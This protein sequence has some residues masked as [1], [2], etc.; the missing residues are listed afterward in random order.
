MYFKNNHFIIIC[1]S[2]IN[3]KDKY[4]NFIYNFRRVHFCYFLL[5]SA[6]TL[7]FLSARCTYS[8]SYL[9]YSAGSQSYDRIYSKSGLNLESLASNGLLSDSLVSGSNHRVGGSSMRQ[10]TSL[11]IIKCESQDPEPLKMVF[12]MALSDFFDLAAAFC[13]NLISIVKSSPLASLL[14]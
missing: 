1:S 8:N 12:S 5:F 10:Q 11:L 6:A 13:T 4:L 2:N 7:S 3:S 14:P 9:F